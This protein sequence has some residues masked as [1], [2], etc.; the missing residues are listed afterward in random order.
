MT[1]D[2]NLPP[3]H[4]RV[5]DRDATASRSGTTGWMIGLLILALVIIG[6]FFVWPDRTAEVAG[7]SPDTTGTTATRPATPADPAPAPAPA[8]AP[9]PAPAQPAPAPAPAPAPTDA[10]PATPQ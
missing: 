5:R 1:Y 4:D 6:A 8:P 9:T 3:S 2:P 7:G 10:A